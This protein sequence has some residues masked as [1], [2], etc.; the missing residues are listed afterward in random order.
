MTYMQAREFSLWHMDRLFELG[1]PPELFI[2]LSKEKD[3][4]LQS[5][6][7]YYEDYDET[8]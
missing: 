2:Q 5:S 8:V 3:W 7:K 1:Y 6:Q 4:F